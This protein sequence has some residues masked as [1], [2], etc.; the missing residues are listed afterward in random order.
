MECRGYTSSVYEMSKRYD[1]AITRV[2]WK[3]WTVGNVGGE[4]S[5]PFE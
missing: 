5:E 1:W 4:I 3:G 2:S